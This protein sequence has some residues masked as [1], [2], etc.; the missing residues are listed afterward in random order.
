MP[1][2]RE[3]LESTY[4]L[5]KMKKARIFVYVTQVVLT[6]ILLIIL[7]VLSPDAG[8]DPLYL[9]FGM[10]LLI[11]ALMLVIFVAQGFF[12]K[13]FGIKW[14]KTDSERFLM[15][16]GYTKKGIITIILA[17]VVIAFANILSPMTDDGIDSTEEVIVDDD[18]NVTFMSQDTFAITGITTITVISSDD[19]YLDVSILLKEDYDNGY[20]VQRLNSDNWENMLTME[21]KSETEGDGYIPYGEYVLY[22]DA[23]GRNANVTYSLERSVSQTIVLELT[24]FPGILV[25]MSAIWVIYLLPLKKRWEKTSIYE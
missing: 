6:V 19:I 16:K 14:A 4:T 18:F 17:V 23:Q 10:Y 22:I 25:G 24:I 9:P 5:G 13:L 21:Y 2:S 20:F 8:I 12:F 7:T 15:A 1:T 3:L 11:L